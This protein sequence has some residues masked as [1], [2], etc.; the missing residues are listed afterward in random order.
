MTRLVRASE[1][2]EMLWGC[3]PNRGIVVVIRGAFDASLDRPAGITA[4]AGYVGDSDDWGPVEEKW[5]LLLAVKG[6]QR[7]RL[8]EVFQRYRQQDA[9]ECALDFA[10]IIA[11]SNLRSVYAYI[12]DTDWTGLDKDSEYRRIYPRPQ[13]ACLDLFLG[14]LSSELDLQFKGQP[15]AI[16][17]D[18]DYDKL[19]YA[20]RIYDT[21]RSR[22]NHPGFGAIAFIKGT[23][24]WDV[25]PLQCADL[26]AGIIRK[27]PIAID[28]LKGPDDRTNPP[29]LAKSVSHVRLRAM[30]KGGRGTHWSLAVAKE[31]EELLRKYPPSLK[32]ETAKILP[33]ASG[34]T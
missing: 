34:T 32:E 11:Q 22:N 21:W 7:F 2:E 12:L 3:S 8:N 19:E 26:L 23:M 25:V 24:N 13:H 14:V 29:M 30:A 31:M 6:M 4:I 5:N 17:F 10:D 28:D 15:N 18:N 9:V 27:D 16:V 20:A 33:P 1:L